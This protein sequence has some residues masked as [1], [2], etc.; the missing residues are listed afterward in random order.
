MICGQAH[1]PVRR[2]WCHSFNR[3]ELCRFYRYSTNNFRMALISGCK[4]FTDGTLTVNHFVYKLT[5]IGAGDRS[6]GQRMLDQD[7]AAGG[8][9]E[10][11]CE[12]TRSDDCPVELRF[13]EMVFGLA[14][15]ANG[16]TQNKSWYRNE[17]FAALVAPDD[18]IRCRLPTS[19]RTQLP[20]VKPL[21]PPCNRSTLTAAKF[22]H[23]FGF[24]LRP[25]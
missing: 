15:L 19:R 21:P 24:L 10:Y 2:S 13:P 9:F 1:S 17:R 4:D 25:L 5:K 23:Q 7:A 16:M 8:F 12:S 3:S 22:T 20:L 6:G 14:L 11:R 18:I